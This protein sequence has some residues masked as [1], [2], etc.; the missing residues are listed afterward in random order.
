MIKKPLGEGGVDFYLTACSPSWRQIKART[1]D[2][3][4]EARAEAEATEECCLLT[5]S[6]W[7]AQS[8]FSFNLGP[9]A[10]DCTA[11]SG[12]ALLDQ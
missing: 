3:N 4:L 6:P 8:S 2:R 5:S 9:S 12:L 7:T 10:Q 11:C 1:P